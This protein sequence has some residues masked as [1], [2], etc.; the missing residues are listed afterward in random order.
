MYA[1]HYVELECPECKESSWEV[2]CRAVVYGPDDYDL[3]PVADDPTGYLGS[4]NCPEC[5]EPGEQI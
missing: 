3:V 4:F 1:A 5:G 2:Y